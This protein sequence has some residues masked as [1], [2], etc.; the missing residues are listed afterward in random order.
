MRTF[1][2]LYSP[3]TFNKTREDLTVRSW[4]YA[5]T[6]IPIWAFTSFFIGV[7]TADYSQIYDQNYDYVHKPEKMM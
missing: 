3:D 2:Y 5:T 1:F 4:K 6:A 7:I